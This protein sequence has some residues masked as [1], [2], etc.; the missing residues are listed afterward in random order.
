[1]D[2]QLNNYV[3]FNGKEQWSFP[4]TLHRAVATIQALERGLNRLTQHSPWT[5]QK[6]KK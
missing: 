3:I 5:I 1:M 6:A 4:M 2:T